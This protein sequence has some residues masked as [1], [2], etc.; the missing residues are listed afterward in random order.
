MGSKYLCICLFLVTLLSFGQNSKSDTF[1]V[2]NLEEAK[3]ISKKENKNI[4]LYFGGSDWCR[5]CMMLQEDFFDDYK[6]T[7]YKKAF[8]FLYVDIPRNR[9]LL[10][11]EQKEENYKLLEAYNK[12]KT[13]PL[14]SILNTKGKVLEELSGYSSLRDPKYHFELLEKY[15]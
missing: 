2:Y 12:K 4:V 15:N 9:N 10:T 7:T 13:F 3:E 14:V 1:W 11:A 5:P 6:F 8:V